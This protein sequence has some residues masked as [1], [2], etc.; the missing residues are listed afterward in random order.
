MSRFSARMSAL[1]FVAILASGCATGEAA[2][3]RVPADDVLAALGGEAPTVKVYKT[4]T[5]GC[6]AVWVEHMQEA[7]FEVEVEDTNDIAAV[8]AEAGLPP[9]LQSC[10]TSFIGDYAFE[11]H[12]P[13]Q[14]I[15]RFL[16]EKPDVKGLAVPGMPVGSPGMEMGDRVDPYDVLAWS[17][18]GQTSVYES[19]R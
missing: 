7:G 13:A 11:G 17:E 1:A 16:A 8:K 9:Q 10:H 2:Q 4:P 3:D 19:F 15:A 14:T 5:C 6:C 18:G 12:I